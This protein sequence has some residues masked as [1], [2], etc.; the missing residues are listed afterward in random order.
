MLVIIFTTHA[1]AEKASPY[2]VLH[3]GTGVDIGSSFNSPLAIFYDTERNEVY[4]ADTGNKQIVIFDDNGLPIHRFYHHVMKDGERMLGEPKGIVVDPEGRIFVTDGV[5][6]SLNVIDALGRIA[7]TI[8]PPEDSCGAQE[9]FQH[10]ALAP[11][12]R[13]YATIACKKDR[14]IAVINPE[15]EIERELRLPLME[16]ST[17]PFVTAIAVDASGQIYLSEPGSPLMIQVYDNDGKYVMGFGR[18]ETGFENFSLPVGIVVMP[19][20]D[21]WIVDTLRQVVS[22]FSSK[23]EFVGYIGGG[24]R[25]PGALFYPTGVASDGKDRLFVVEKAG[26]RY[27]CFRI[28]SDPSSP[29]ET[30]KQS[31]AMHTSSNGGR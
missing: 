10:V 20:G 11:D 23:G 22:R 9:C 16:G 1:H 14:R 31:E 15:L 12:G 29:P 6:P 3:L 17:M 7:K 24:G 27:Q 18:H 25:Q 5:V 30:E 2:E 13:V 4:V 26:N 28:L 19:N 21:M 8:T